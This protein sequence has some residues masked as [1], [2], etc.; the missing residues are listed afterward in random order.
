[1]TC[2][3]CLSASDNG[4]RI[5]VKNRDEDFTV[6]RDRP[7]LAC[8]MCVLCNG[9]SVRYY[10]PTGGRSI[11]T[12]RCFKFRLW[13]GAMGSHSEDDPWRDPSPGNTNGR[14][15][16]D[17]RHRIAKDLYPDNLRNSKDTAGA[18]PERVCPVFRQ[19]LK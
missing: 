3:V 11:Y 5:D 9:R 4:G 10:I 1:M 13:T 17:C 2:M 18:Y 14:Y 16:P 6:S 8:R 19:I 7:A 15:G 12:L